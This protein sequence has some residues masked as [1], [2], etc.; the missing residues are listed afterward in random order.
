MSLLSLFLLS[1][2]MSAD[3]FAAAIGKGAASPHLRLRDV[4][5]C[6]TVFATIE[7]I[8]PVLGWAAGR[9][10]A[11]WIAQWDHW[12]AFSLLALLGLNM[13]RQAYKGADDAVP[14]T[15][16]PSPICSG[17][18]VLTAVATSIDAAAAGVSLSIL[19]VSIVQAALMIGACTLVAA[20]VGI[21][22]G[23][24]LGQWGGR[25]AEALGGVVLISI[26]SSLLY[27][28][29]SQGI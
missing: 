14:N 15:A 10:A 21:L 29:L 26:G 6:A 12:L 2:A 23:R 17:A 25:V 22:C 11:P 13:L 28:H 16:P 24:A 20:C 4:A 1:L 18:M 19:D 5:C 3:A 7:M 27:E 8:T 9:A